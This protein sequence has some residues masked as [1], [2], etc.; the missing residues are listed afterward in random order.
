MGRSGLCGQ[1]ATGT[2]RMQSLQMLRGHGTALTALIT[3]LFDR[4]ARPTLSAR[5]DQDIF[6][7]NGFRTSY[8][9]SE[10][11]EA[12]GGVVQ[13]YASTQPEAESLAE[14]RATRA[15]GP[16]ISVLQAGPPAQVMR[17]AKLTAEI[18]GCRSWKVQ[19]PG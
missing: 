19:F 17:S 7:H 3:A 11:G 15:D 10:E 1:R 13:A 18:L 14:V 6:Y 2:L 8:E 5:S 9:V 12:A 4:C 16:G